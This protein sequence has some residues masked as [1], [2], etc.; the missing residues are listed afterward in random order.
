MWQKLSGQ[1]K[2]YVSI[3]MALLIGYCAYQLSFRKTIEAIALNSELAAEQ[4]TNGATN[5]AT[6]QNGVKNDFYNKVLSYY[7]IKSEDPEA[8]IWESI[9]SISQTKGV[10]I[11]FNPNNKLVPDSL[12]LKKKILHRDFSFRGSYFGLIALVDS[13]SRTP[14]IGRVSSLRINV[15]KE[16]RVDG[17]LELKLTMMGM[18]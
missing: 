7:R 16:T 11:G 18:R 1:H 6:G 10:S 9:S 3:G 8:M 12:A 17:E 13:I 14:G 4:V 5:G 2:N 15:P